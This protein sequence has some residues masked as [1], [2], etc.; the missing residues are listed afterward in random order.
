MFFL[1]PG[2]LVWYSGSNEMVIGIGN[3]DTAAVVWIMPAR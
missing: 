3:F 1:K 2:Y